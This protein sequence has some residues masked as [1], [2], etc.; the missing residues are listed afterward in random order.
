MLILNS[1]WEGKFGVYINTNLE[2]TLGIE[3]ERYSVEMLD[4]WYYPLSNYFRRNS[5]GSC[6]IG[7]IFTIVWILQSHAL[8]KFLTV[9]FKNKSVGIWKVE[10]SNK[11][12][13]KTS[14][15][16]LGFWSEIHAGYLKEKKIEIITN[17]EDLSRHFFGYRYFL[18]RMIVY[19]K[20]TTVFLELIVYI[21]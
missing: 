1:W 15:V 13:L 6:E 16:Y 8:K 14:G 4:I 5:I 12:N 19:R 10:I 17:R 11:L 9:R 7:F 21:L 18:I 2:V 3:N 20:L